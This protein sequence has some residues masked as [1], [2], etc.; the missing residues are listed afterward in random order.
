MNSNKTSRNNKFKYI[1]LSNKRRFTK[2]KIEENCKQNQRNNIKSSISLKKSFNKNKNQNNYY[3]RLL[4]ENF[5]NISIMKKIKDSKDE[6]N[7]NCL[8]TEYLEINN[9]LIDEGDKLDDYERLIF[10]LDYKTVEHNNISNSKKN[11]LK[12]KKDINHKEN[13]KI[14]DNNDKSINEILFLKKENEKLKKILNEMKNNFEKIKNEQL[15]SN[16]MEKE[17]ILQLNNENEKISLKLKN[18]FE[19]NNQ[20]NN[21]IQKLNNCIL[22][23]NK[24]IIE[25]KNELSQRDAQIEKLI[26]EKNDLIHENDKLLNQIIQNKNE[27]INLNTQIKKLFNESEIKNNHI[28]SLTS[29]LQNIQSEKQIFQLINQ[30]DSKTI[31]SIILTYKQRQLELNNHLLILSKYNSEKDKII[32]NLNQNIIFYKTKCQENQQKIQTFIENLKDLKKYVNEVENM[33]LSKKLNE[34]NLNTKNDITKKMEHKG[35]NVQHLNNDNF[36]KKYID[37]NNDLLNSLRNMI[38]NID[39][40]IKDNI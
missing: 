34:L 30:K 3:R 22:E 31:T 21:I 6:S 18:I 38:L 28:T 29:L 37:Y 5:G 19:E 8:T 14:G 25:S 12:E 23:Y 20:K 39:T 27:S 13:N 35:F 15:K 4:S 36:E 40:K 7:Y 16:S 10:G 17:K 26:K 24:T 2:V 33:L 1:S 32:N 9:K 11:N